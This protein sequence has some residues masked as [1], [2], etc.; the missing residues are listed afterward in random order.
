M[1]T[2]TTLIVALFTLSATPA[3]AAPVH[4]RQAPQASS[5]WNSQ[6]ESKFV[7]KFGAAL[8][9]TSRQRHTIARLQSNGQRKLAPLAEQKADLKSQLAR[10]E[11]KP[12]NQHR[13]VAQT[14]RQ[15][16]WVKQQMKS[17]KVETR[18]AVK[19]QL[20]PRQVRTLE[21]IK[22]SKGKSYGK[23]KSYGKSNGK[24]YGKSKSRSGGRHS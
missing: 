20:S 4:G 11:S 1:K 24:S 19:E 13:R 6:P 9:L 2:L 23:N 10:L 21:N 18:V 17:V 5:S 7:T 15:L 16:T 12:G 14:E 8:D 22:Q 3:I